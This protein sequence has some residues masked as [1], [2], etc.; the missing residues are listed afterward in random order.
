M[1]DKR[2]SP[3]GK[4]ERY[5]LSDRA[6]LMALLEALGVL[7]HRLT[8]EGI[9]IVTDMGNDNRVRIHLD[10]KGE[11]RQLLSEHALITLSLEALGVLA[12]RQTGKGIE[13][14]VEVDERNQF[15]VV[16]AGMGEAR[17]VG[18]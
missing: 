4:D 13:I 16:L 17:V 11:A 8:G 2:V 12:Q 3:P 1:A 9:E 10:G 7:A 6:L 14:L 5:I 15:R 18:W